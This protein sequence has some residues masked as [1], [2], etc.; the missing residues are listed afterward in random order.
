MI[1]ALLECDFATI[2][3]KQNIQAHNLAAFASTCNLPFQPNHK[4]TAEVKRGPNIPNNLKYWQIFSQ[5]E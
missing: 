4:Y 5:D 3:R 2:P 1:K